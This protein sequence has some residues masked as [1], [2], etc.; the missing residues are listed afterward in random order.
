VANPDPQTGGERR[1]PVD[2][3]EVVVVILFIGHL[4]R[5]KLKQ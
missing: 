5:Q 4:P 2:T 3:F 1:K